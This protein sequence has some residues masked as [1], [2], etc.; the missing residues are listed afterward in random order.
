MIRQTRS[1]TALAEPMG[2]NAV[3]RSARDSAQS[4]VSIIFQRRIDDASFDEYWRWELRSAEILSGRPG[5]IDQDVIP[6]SPPVQ[7]DWVTVQ[8]FST[9]DDAR[10][11]LDS[12]DRTA[13]VAEIKHA[14][15]GNEDVHLLTGEQTAAQAASSVVISCRI[16]PEDE[17]AFLDWQRRISAAE[18]RFVGFRGHKV[19]RPV[20]GVTEDWTIV[21]SFDTEDNLERW[22]NSAERAELLEQG[23]KFNQDLR[24]R[25]ASYGFDFWFRGA[26]NVQSAEVPVARSN[27][28]VLLVL[29]PLVVIWGHFVSAPLIEARGVPV[30]V[31]LFI[32]N[33]VTTQI[34]GWWAVPAAFK[35]FGW[36]MDPA[37]SPS[38]RN[39]GYAVM[40]A[41]FGVSIAVCTLLFAIPTT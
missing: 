5:F 29:Y 38:R 30:A 4:P 21:L 34:L 20:R 22:L 3:P 11:W 12:D 24:V 25:R 15:I 23:A 31:A 19:E 16:D 33:V 14:F 37:I 6:P 2:V 27:L 26:K 7:D 35:A 9:L 40:I 39:L 10:T 8:R 17:S 13:L 41:L 1:H 36:W 28:L 18:A 32:G